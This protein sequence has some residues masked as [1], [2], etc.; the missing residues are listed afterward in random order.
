M[1]SKLR[2]IFLRLLQSNF[3]FV[4]IVSLYIFVWHF[5]I[6]TFFYLLWQVLMDDLI[7]FG[8]AHGTTRHTQNLTSTAWVIYCPSGQLM[9]S[10]GVCIGSALNNIAENIVILNLLSEAISY[11]IDSLVVY[12]DSQLIVSQLNNIYQ[13]RDP[14]LYRQYLRVRFGAIAPSPLD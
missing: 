14:C 13:V 10:R 2:I 12:L 7:Y 1:G 3:L 8:F 9:V 6:S 5:V 4:Y 11:E